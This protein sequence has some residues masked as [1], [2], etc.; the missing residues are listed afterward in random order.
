MAIN[1]PS[2]TPNY[3]LQQAS[4][5]VDQSSNRISSGQ[6]INSA[7]DDAAGLAIS[8]GLTSQING[9]RQSIR[10][11]SDGISFAQTKSGAVD[12]MLENVQR[13]RELAVQ[14]GNG[15]YTDADREILNKEAQSLT[16]QIKSTLENS[17]FNG[18]SLFSES[19]SQVFQ[20]GP[21]NGDT[22]T[23]DQTNLRDEV[24]ELGIDDVSISTQES[25]SNTIDF[26][27]SLIQKF[28]QTGAEIGAV[29]NRFESRVDTLQQQEITATASRSRIQDADIAKE[30]S[31]LSQN[32]VREQAA[33]AVQAQ[34]N[35][36]AG[37][38]LKLLG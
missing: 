28:T 19:S 23:V 15:T 27:D 36:N 25:A 22:L 33:I 31:L 12:S 38:I 32:N 35:L 34:A 37:N 16:D 14:S 6:R 3:S 30:A 18:K 21:N 17:N 29:Q 4:N 10:N 11:V 13:L 5:A 20:V 8:E 26:A 7:A 24:T 1:F 2:S 9:Q